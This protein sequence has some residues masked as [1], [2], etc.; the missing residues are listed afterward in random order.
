MSDLT[1]ALRPELLESIARR[2]AD[3]VKADAAT[4]AV[5]APLLDLAGQPPSRFGA[6]RT[7]EE[8]PERVR[9]RLCPPIDRQAHP[10]AGVYEAKLMSRARPAGPRGDHRRLEVDDAP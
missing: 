8:V 9:Q 1:V 4:Q 5:A 10:R 7:P 6:P 2:A 3:L